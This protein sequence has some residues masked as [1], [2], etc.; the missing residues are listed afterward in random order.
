MKYLA[1]SL[2]SALLGFWAGAVWCILYLG[3]ED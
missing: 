3:D 2:C 1:L